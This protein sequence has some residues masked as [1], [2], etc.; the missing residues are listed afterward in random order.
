MV[1][2]SNCCAPVSRPSWV[3]LSEVSFDSKR[4][5]GRPLPPPPPPPGGALPLG[6]VSKN[7][8]LFPPGSALLSDQSKYAVPLKLS[9]PSYSRKLFGSLEPTSLEDLSLILMFC[10]NVAPPS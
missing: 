8:A 2:L 9:T 4:S 7:M 10:E 6:R 3:G 1:R 5:S